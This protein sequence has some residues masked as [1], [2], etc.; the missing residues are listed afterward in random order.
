MKQKYEE[1][2]AQTHEEDKNTE[3]EQDYQKWG[4]EHENI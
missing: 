4:D 2:G 3:D 1:W